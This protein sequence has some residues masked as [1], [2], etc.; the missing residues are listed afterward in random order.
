MSKE[1][2]PDIPL[3][4]EI[5]YATATSVLFHLAV[6]SPHKLKPSYFKFMNKITGNRY[7][8][9]MHL[10]FL[11][12]LSKNIVGLFKSALFMYIGNIFRVSQVNRF[13]LDYEYGEAG[14]E[15]SLS[16]RHVPNLEWSRLSPR[17]RAVWPRILADHDVTVVTKG[18]FGS[19]AN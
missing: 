2:L 9:F 4:K 7:Y 8:N 12:R 10:C 11:I 14:T 5:I 6:V 19:K 15:A 3:A 16:V 13:L 1:V 17:M 18:S